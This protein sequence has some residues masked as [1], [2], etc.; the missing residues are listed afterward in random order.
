MKLFLKTK[1]FSVSGEQFE[2]HWDEDLDMLVTRPQ[3]KNIAVYYE[4]E[5]YI[6]HTDSKKSFTDRLY[7][8]VKRR[9]L[10]TKTQLV[11]N[12]IDNGRTL[13]DFGAGTGD[14]LITAQNS[15][16]K[17][18]GI[19]PNVNARRLAA[20]KGMELEPDL[21]TLSGQKFKAITL[22]HVLEHLPNLEHDISSLVSL[23]EKEGVLVIAVPNF[24][25]FDAKYYKSHWAAYDVPRHL[26]HFSKKSISEL[27]SRHNMEIIKIKPMWFDAFYVSMLSEKYKGNSLHMIRAFFVGLWSNCSAIVTKEHSSLIY[28]LKKKK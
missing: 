15:G 2:L 3:P 21:E 28:I 17:T 20:K 14:F 23:L 8:L 19:E 26:W 22:W 12:Q 5:D 1:D 24:K 18:V 25:S 27:F 13:L 4:S 6:S 9:N 11:E 7:Q 16:F 10:N